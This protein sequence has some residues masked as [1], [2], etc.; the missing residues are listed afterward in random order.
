MPSDEDFHRQMAEGYERQRKTQ[1]E[2]DAERR[3]CHFQCRLDRQLA[4]KLRHYCES[5]D[6]NVNQALQIIISK[7]FK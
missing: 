1:A 7:F 6:L 5:R 2:M 3:D 4:S